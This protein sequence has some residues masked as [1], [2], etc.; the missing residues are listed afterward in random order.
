MVTLASNDV[1]H[2]RNPTLNIKIDLATIGGL[3]ETG[4]R[5][6]HDE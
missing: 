4:G 3:N 1:E 2:H 5:D 6:A